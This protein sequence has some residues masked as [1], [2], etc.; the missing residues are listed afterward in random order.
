MFKTPF[1]DQIIALRKKHGLRTPFD[2]GA[3]L[4]APG[5]N[6]GVEDRAEYARRFRAYQAEVKGIGRP[7]IERAKVATEQR[8]KYVQSLREKQKKAAESRKQ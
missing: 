5:Q 8:A 4:A 6:A 3:G 7:Q 2:K 1:T